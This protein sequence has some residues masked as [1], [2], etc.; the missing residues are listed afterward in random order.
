MTELMQNKL[1]TGGKRKIITWQKN[2]I[3]FICLMPVFF[4]TVKDRYNKKIGKS[5]SF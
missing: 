1:D 5:N 4:L 2:F 3:C